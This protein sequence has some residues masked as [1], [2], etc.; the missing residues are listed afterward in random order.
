M[1]TWDSITD[2][3]SEQSRK[4]W[5]LL[6]WGWGSAAARRSA[7]VKER[8]GARWE[9]Q[10]VSLP[11]P[12]WEG[13]EV[14]GVTSNVGSVAFPFLSPVVVTTACSCLEWQKWPAHLQSDMGKAA[15]RL[16]P[17][18]CL[19]WSVIRGNCLLCLNLE[20]ALP[21]QRLYL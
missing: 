18:C 8:A 2:W 14:C 12:L 1:D 3:V 10:G 6:V 13:W 4:T 21:I 20:I 7:E 19:W 5:I 16:W 15:R 11:A 17:H 9:R